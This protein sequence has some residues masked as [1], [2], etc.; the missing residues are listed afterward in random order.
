MRI[1]GYIEHPHLKIT[2]FK[3]NNRLSIKFES[4]LYEQVY[5][6]RESEQINNAASLQEMVN[7]E[8][9]KA[10][11][12]DFIKMHQRIMGAIQK[13]TPSSEDE[14]DAIL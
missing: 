12:E 3:L 4:G 8:F 5:K 6:M 13:M 10:V 11:E 2:L 9:I 7:D 1:I 14:F